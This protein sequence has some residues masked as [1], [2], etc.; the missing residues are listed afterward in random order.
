MGKLAGG[1]ASTDGWKDG[2][3]R[4]IVEP[5]RP[6]EDWRL[7]E[8]DSRT[9]DK[10]SVDDLLVVLASVSPDV[11]RAVWDFQRMCNPGWTI[12][13]RKPGAREEDPVYTEAQ[14]LV[15]EFLERLRSRHIVEDVIWNRL[16][17]G[18]YIRGA[19]AAE[20]VLDKDARTPLDIAVPDPV[21]IRF[22]RE[23]RG[24]L[25]EVYVP[26]Q[27]QPR[28]WVS[29]DRPTFFYV[30]VDP[31]PGSPYGRSPAAPA[32]FSSL[33]LIGMLHDLRRV[34]SQQGYPRVD[35]AVS[36]E[37]LA[38]AMPADLEGDPEA[39]MKWVNEIVSE[40]Q[41]VYAS[42]EPDDAYVHTDTIEINRPIGTVDANSLGA[43]DGI[44]K[45]LERMSIKALKTMP[46]LMGVQDSSGS[47]AH[48]ARQWE[49]F[50]QG[51]SSL[52]HLAE[53]LLGRLFTLALRAQGMAAEVKFRFA[54]LRASEELRDAQTESIKIA[55]AQSK[56]MNGWYSQ[57]QASMEVTGRP[58]DV[59]EPRQD[60]TQKALEMANDTMK[61]TEDDSEAEPEKP[62][63]GGPKDTQKRSLDPEIEDEDI[64]S[65]IE[66][67]DAVMRGYEGLLN[68]E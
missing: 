26:G 21:T 50:A 41:R 42:L 12:E 66:R 68:A 18:A 33:F 25:G 8:L 11:S 54:K 62:Q 56:Y 37:K 55:N 5:D 47:D 36:L 2:Y 9:L 45:A 51:V 13:V 52:Q 65:A 43:I 58:P 34:I 10:I 15:D 7:L 32:L 38:T 40:V 35:I 39:V 4:A 59:P 3:W 63:P 27:N 20:L 6:E 30:P 48:T 53:N 24:P 22:K 28:Q 46:L 14:A 49:I 31:M 57:E 67:W 29:L 17:M 1:R 23:R 60:P 61:D 64:S 19:F 16:F 44:I